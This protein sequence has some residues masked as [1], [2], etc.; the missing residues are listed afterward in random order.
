MDSGDAAVLPGHDVN[1]LFFL[2]NTNTFPG[3]MDKANEDV[4]SVRTYKQ[5]IEKTTNIFGTLFPDLSYEKALRI[6]Q[7]WIDAK[8]SNQVCIVNVHSLINGLSDKGFQTICNNSLSTMDG[9]PLVWYANLVHQASIK[10]K[11][12]GPDL[13]LECLDKGRGKGWKHFFVGSTPAVLKDLVVEMESRFPGVEIAGWNSPPFRPLSDR[14]DQD[15]VDQINAAKPDFLWVG[16]GAPKQEK[17]IADHL[18]RIHAPVQ[19]GVGAAFSFHSGHVSRAPHWMRKR[20][21]EWAYRMLKERRLIRRY[22][23]SNPVFL[24]LFLKDLIKIRI[25]KL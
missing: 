6:F 14:E 2:K 11:V 5:G 25:L 7:G 24:A 13:M 1:G 22:L 17:W 4:F 9:V 20:G 19:L 8:T 12:C 15:L 18:H 21:L 23:S 16:L 10:S 3:I